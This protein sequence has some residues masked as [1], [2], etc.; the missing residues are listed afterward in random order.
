M[1]FNYLF[2]PIVILFS[3]C[4]KNENYIPQDSQ[5]SEVYKKEEND[6]GK[7]L[8]LINNI[9]QVEDKIIFSDIINRR[10]SVWDGDKFQKNIG[11]E[12]EAPGQ[13]K[14]LSSL[15]SAG[16]T[17]FVWDKERLKL[18]L[19]KGNKYISSISLDNYG[20]K[21]VPDKIHAIKNDLLLVEYS[22][23]FSQ[24]DQNSTKNRKRYI[25]MIDLN[26]NY[27]LKEAIEID[28]KEFNVDTNSGGMT[29]MVR[30]F[31]HEPFVN[32][33]D[34]FIVLAHSSENKI[35]IIDVSNIKI[36][37][38]ITFDEV[39]SKINNKD[40]QQEIS[41]YKSNTDIDKL[42]EKDRAKKWRQVE[43]LCIDRLNKNIWIKQVVSGNHEKAIWSVYNLDGNKLK[44]Y[45]LP[46]SYDIAIID[47]QYTIG[48]ET[49]KLGIQSIIKYKISK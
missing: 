1:K 17:L 24:I 22:S 31:G 37:K 32:Y 3:S 33:V 23:G 34:N 46:F 42:L 10:I 29:V 49:N 38:D 8:G 11:S 27:L 14:L 12:G 19:F 6:I 16:D 28:D 39:D 47:K 44:E 45:V 13:F 40:F 2:L 26:Q 41:R 43:D 30:P 21:Y 7:P 36:K 25:Q 35:S 4:K 5:F 20:H 15:T 9:I 18:N 48:V